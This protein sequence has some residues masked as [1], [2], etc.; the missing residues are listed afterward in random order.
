MQSQWRNNK[1]SNNKIIVEKKN[2]REKGKNNKYG[3]NKI[4]KKAEELS[5]IDWLKL[6]LSIDSKGNFISLLQLFIVFY[7]LFFF[8]VLSFLCL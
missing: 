7:F 5:L 4:K 2:K 1:N 8:S 6:D 3:K